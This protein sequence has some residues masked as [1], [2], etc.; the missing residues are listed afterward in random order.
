MPPRGT[1]FSDAALLDAAEAVIHD[2]GLGNL[3]LDAVAARAGV[4]KGG[5][6]YHF[7]SKDALLEAMVRRIV[8]TWR[9]DAAASIDRAPPGPGRVA[10]GVMSLCLDRPDCGGEAMRRSGFVL[11]TAL[12]NNPELIKPLRD[13]HTDLLRRA[14][15]DGLGAGVS[16]CVILSL[17]GLWFERIFGLSEMTPRRREDLLCALRSLA[18]TPLVG[19][20]KAPAKSARVKSKVSRASRSRT[21]K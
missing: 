11:V 12:V 8:G 17:S 10:R 6:M 7:K 5:L 14:E 9:D 2:E 3:T 13:A 4:S 18:G 21:K 20:K 16:A 15:D 1:N 19:A